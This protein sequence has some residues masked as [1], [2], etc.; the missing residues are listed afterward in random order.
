MRITMEGKNTVAMLNYQRVK[1]KTMG[2]FHD[3][4]ATAQEA[5]GSSWFPSPRE[6]T[7]TRF[8][9]KVVKSCSSS[10]YGAICGFILY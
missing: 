1:M 2:S 6:T 5:S 4:R 3:P 8:C 10:Y 9:A 7:C